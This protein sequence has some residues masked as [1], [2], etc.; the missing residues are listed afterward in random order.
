MTEEDE[1]FWGRS[2]RIRGFFAQRLQPFPAIYYDE[3]LPELGMASRDEVRLGPE[4]FASDIEVCVLAHEL[5]HV[6]ANRGAK[7]EN[8]KVVQE[9]VP[10]FRL[11]FTES[12]AYARINLNEIITDQLARIAS[13]RMGERFESSYIIEEMPRDFLFECAEEAHRAVEGA[14]KRPGDVTRLF[15]AKRWLQ[16]FLYSELTCLR[17]MYPVTGG[18]E[19]DYDLIDW[20]IV[21]ADALDPIDQLIR[22]PLQDLDASLLVDGVG[23]LARDHAWQFGDLS[24]LWTRMWPLECLER[25][26]WGND[27]EDEEVVVAFLEGVEE[28]LREDV[29]DRRARDQRSRQS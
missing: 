16:P 3:A 21:L 28:R 29:I 24:P 26:G 14:L 12:P 20:P 27:Q 18:H 13:A 17:L 10:S 4:A 2:E 15:L 5:F 11:Q 23:G 6:V 22:K 1:D 9:I 25:Q 19:K 7:R 8:L